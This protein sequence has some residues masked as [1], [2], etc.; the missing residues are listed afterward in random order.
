VS[1]GRRQIGMTHHGL[2]CH[3]VSDRCDCGGDPSAER[4]EPNPFRKRLARICVQ[5]LCAPTGVRG[6]ER[7]C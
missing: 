5:P 1:G 3:R 6:I 4:V 7:I 2:G